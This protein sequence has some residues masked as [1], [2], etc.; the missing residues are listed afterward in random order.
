MC[1]V[2]RLF[3]VSVGLEGLEGLGG[4]ECLEGLEGL[5]LGL[6]AS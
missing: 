5:G 3:W 6:T 4:R 2:Y 1:R